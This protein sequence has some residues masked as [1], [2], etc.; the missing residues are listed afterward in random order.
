MDKDTRGIG[1][2]SVQETNYKTL[3]ENLIAMVLEP[4]IDI[5]MALKDQIERARTATRLA[6]KF[7]ALHHAEATREMCEDRLNTL[8]HFQ[9]CS[10]HKKR[11]FVFMWT[12][13]QS[14][15]GSKI[16]DYYLGLGLKEKEYEWGT[17]WKDF[18][19]KADHGE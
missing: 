9:Q 8:E 11:P 18:P 13:L 10:K 3:F 14:Q 12:K 15:Y 5:D 19:D 7:E 4:K 6:D 2:N 17:S 16:H 1:D